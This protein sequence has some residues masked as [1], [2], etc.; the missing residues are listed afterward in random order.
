[1]QTRNIPIKLANPETGE[2]YINYTAQVPVQNYEQ[3]LQIDELR[4]A[5]FMP[6]QNAK[7][8]GNTALTDSIPMLRG[9]YGVTS[10]AGLDAA[11]PI[12][13]KLM[14]SNMDSAEQKANLENEDIKR[15]TMLNLMDLASKQENAKNFGIVE[16][17]L[18]A[19]T[20]AKI[21]P[22]YAGLSFTNPTT[23]MQM[24]MQMAMNQANLDSQ[25][26]ARDQQLAIAQMQIEAA[27]NRSAM[28]AAS[29]GGYGQTVTPS[30]DYS[31]IH[32]LRAHLQKVVDDPDMSDEAKLQ[33]LA[34]FSST[35]LR[36][37]MAK[38]PTAAASAINMLRAAGNNIYYGK[39]EEW[40]SNLMRGLGANQQQE[41][42]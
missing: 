21:D 7:Q 38:S 42:E 39:G 17:A 33:E 29:R 3:A 8:A 19:M 2:D 30:D 22:T 14:Q 31:G 12:L 28:T 16:S 41:Q 4:K 10:K 35:E 23:D 20:G 13:S 18:Q 6:L 34:N 26:A 40:Y 27:N 15:Q 11:M 1:M 37:L 5:S 25:K 9:A 32:T 36:P 24:G